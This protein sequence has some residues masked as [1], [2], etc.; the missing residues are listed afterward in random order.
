MMPFFAAAVLAVI[1]PNPARMS[2]AFAR[3]EGTDL[4]SAR[5]IGDRIFA[6]IEPVQV[7]KIRVESIG[8][9]KVAELVLS[10]VKFHGPVTRNIFVEEVKRLALDALAAA[11]IEEVDVHVTVPLY[12]RAGILVSGDGAAPTQR[13][14]FTLTVRA[15]ESAVA[16]RRRLEHNQGTFWDPTFAQQL[17]PVQPVQ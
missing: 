14:V 4:V 6:R 11:P 7:L 1:L 3:A 8:Q 5:A 13:T 10:G 9:H 17:S 2:D 15:G 16:L 12:Q